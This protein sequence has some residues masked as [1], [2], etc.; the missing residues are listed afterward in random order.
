MDNIDAE[1]LRH[2]LRDEVCAMAFTGTPA[3]ILD[4][5]EIEHADADE[6]IE[7]AKR[8]GLE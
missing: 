2:K 4:G 1:E 6:L 7:I 5:N 8:Y 3:V